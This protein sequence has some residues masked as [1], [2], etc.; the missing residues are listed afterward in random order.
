[1]THIADR[2]GR[3][4]DARAFTLIELLV[5][6][7]ILSLLVAVLLPSL[8]RAK[9]ITLR[10][11]CQSNLRQIG[12]CVHMFAGSHMGRAPGTAGSANGSRNWVNYLNIEV[13]GERDFGGGQA[14]YIQYIGWKP[15]KN[16]IYCP[17]MKPYS[18]TSQWSNVYS[19]AYAINLDVTG[20]ANWDPSP[21][22]GAFGINVDPAPSNPLPAEGGGKWDYYGLGPP[23]EKFQNPSFQFMVLESEHSWEY[24]HAQF[25]YHT[26]ITL[27]DGGSAMPPW[28]GFGDV[29]AFRHVLPNDVSLYQ[30]QATGNFLY[31]DGHVN[32]MTANEHINYEDR[33]YLKNH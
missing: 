19:R 29:Y 10:T 1:V 3:P 5:V 4:R 24:M 14:G 17:S 7:S 12:R 33:F 9:A 27:G 25:P 28:S 11:I 2:P 26:G 8:S 6:V 23:L 20:W 22:W 13:L 31:I 30:A 18:P 16:A 32:Y 21:P 15:R